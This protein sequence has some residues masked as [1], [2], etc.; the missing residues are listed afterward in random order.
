M[1]TD[2][3]QSS[4][5]IQMERLTNFIRKFLAAFLVK[6]TDNLEHLQNVMQYSLYQNREMKTSI[7]ARMRMTTHRAKYNAVQHK[8]YTSG[9]CHCDCNCDSTIS[10]S[11][12]YG[13]I[14]KRSLSTDQ[15]VWW[16][17]WNECVF[18]SY[19][20]YSIRPF[21]TR[22]QICISCD[23]SHCEE[24]AVNY[25]T[26]AASDKKLQDEQHPKRHHFIVGR[27]WVLLD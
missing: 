25:W 26:S 7:S 13:F 20:P 17:T 27:K 18:R 19:T 11:V 23:F 21:V 3:Q 10:L 5:A 12:L 15:A 4:A 6:S 22:F 16:K 9:H 1:S 8:A 14:W 24:C 2:N